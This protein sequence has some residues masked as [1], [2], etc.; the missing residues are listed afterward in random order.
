MPF[1]VERPARQLDLLG[2]TKTKTTFVGMQRNWRPF[3]L[4]PAKVAEI[5]EPAREE[6]AGRAR[7]LASAAASAAFVSR[8]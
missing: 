4:L 7:F 8:G 6:R 2:P 1:R 5:A 3:A